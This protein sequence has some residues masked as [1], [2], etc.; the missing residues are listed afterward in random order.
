MPR[1]LEEKL[2]TAQTSGREIDESHHSLAALCLVGE[3]EVDDDAQHRLPED[4]SMSHV[5]ELRE[6]R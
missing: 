5:T 6:C 2:M 3:G 4:K 1:L